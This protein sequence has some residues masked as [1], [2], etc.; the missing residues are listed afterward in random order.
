[1][2]SGGSKPFI[3]PRPALRREYEVAL[4]QL[5]REMGTPSNLRERWRFWRARRNLWNEL[6]ERPSRSANW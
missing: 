5:R 3:D 1:M 2:S 4:D 6:V